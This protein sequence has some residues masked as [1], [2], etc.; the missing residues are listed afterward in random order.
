MWSCPSMTKVPEACL[1]EAQASS[2][3]SS[4]RLPC[5][6]QD[7]PGGHMQLCGHW[8][9]N[10]LLVHLPKCLGALNTT[11]AQQTQAD[12]CSHLL[13]NSCW[14]HKLG[15]VTNLNCCSLQGVLKCA[16]TVQTIT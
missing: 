12:F 15:R 7:G 13:A 3:C 10:R 14:A 16:V 11:E 4:S 1:P 6:L 5:V 9:R 2:T 8:V